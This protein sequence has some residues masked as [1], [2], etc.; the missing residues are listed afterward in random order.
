M[1]NAYRRA[2]RSA[3]ELGLGPL[4]PLNEAI[5]EFRV[6]QQ[7]GPNGDRTTGQNEKSSIKQ[8]KAEVAELADAADSKSAV[9]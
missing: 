9:P 6:G 4:D 1:I 7:G 3:S 8:A 5:P 2:T